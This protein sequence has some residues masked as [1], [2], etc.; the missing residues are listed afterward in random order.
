MTKMVV[1]AFVSLLTVGCA[2]HSEGKSSGADGSGASLASAQCVDVLTVRGD[3]W[4]AFTMSKRLHR[5]LVGP[6]LKGQ[7]VSCDDGAGDPIDEGQVTL[8]H[9]RGISAHQA[10]FRVGQGYEDVIYVPGDG[11]EKLG[12]LPRTVQ[13]L[14]TKG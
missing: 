11:T 7:P 3:S 5:P 8:R 13:L 10:L 4:G 12:D 6:A 2:S 1:L 9:I 14:I